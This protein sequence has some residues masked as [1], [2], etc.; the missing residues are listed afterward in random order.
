[1]LVEAGVS[2]GKDLQQGRG[3]SIGN[4]LDHDK[5]LAC[6]PHCDR[7]AL[8]VGTNGENWVFCFVLFCFLKS[9]MD[10]V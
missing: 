6:H 4:F 10:V 7:K 5:E 8:E 1:M 3:Q 2:V 9:S